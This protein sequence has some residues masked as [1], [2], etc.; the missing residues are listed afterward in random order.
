MFPTV[1]EKARGFQGMLPP[2]K[3]KPHVSNL[4]LDTRHHGRAAT[5]KD[6]TSKKH[7]SLIR[8][9][10]SVSPREQCS[11]GDVFCAEV[12][13]SILYL[14]MSGLTKQT[15]VFLPD[16][17]KPNLNGSMF[18]VDFSMKLFAPVVFA[19]GPPS[20]SLLRGSILEVWAAPL[21]QHC[22]HRS[23]GSFCFNSRGICWPTWLSCSICSFFCSCCAY[24]VSYM[25]FL[26]G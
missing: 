9:A 1:V 4:F 25:P 10:G 6:G 3:S 23:S 11:Y 26:L 16:F 21:C 22:G 20:P 19:A 8:A 18:V 12:S 13:V 2:H 15:E 24:A 7:W 17:S 5:C 14:Q